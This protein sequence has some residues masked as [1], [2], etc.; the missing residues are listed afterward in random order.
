MKV[1]DISAQFIYRLKVWSVLEYCY[2]TSVSKTKVIITGGAGFIGSHLVDFLVN[3]G[4]EVLIIDN[5]SSSRK[6]NLNPKAFF[7]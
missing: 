7:K 2:N 1:K 5:L 4:F 3:K 6:N